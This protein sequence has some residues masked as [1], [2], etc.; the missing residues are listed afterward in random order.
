MNDTKQKEIESRVV[1]SL[2]TELEK[3]LRY[4]EERIKSIERINKRNEK[5]STRRKVVDADEAVEFHKLNQQ[6][7]RA[8]MNTLRKELKKLNKLTQGV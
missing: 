4:R 5:W 2:L 8:V 7:I 1:E 3:Q 6:A